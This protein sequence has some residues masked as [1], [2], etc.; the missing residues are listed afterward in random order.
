[1]LLR[2]IELATCFFSVWLCAALALAQTPDD[3]TLMDSNYPTPNSSYL[4]SGDA[5]DG[6]N[7]G[8]QWRFQA[9]ALY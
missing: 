7:L 2:K 5:V 9:D 6:M 3:S 4:N 1:M 8:W